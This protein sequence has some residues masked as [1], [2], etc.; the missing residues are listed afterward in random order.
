MTPRSL[1]NIILKVFAL[2]FLRETI[3]AASQLFSAITYF[4]NFDDPIGGILPIVLTVL[5]LA[6]YV[7]L[8]I[9]LLFKTNNFI[10]KL[11]LDR[12]FDEHEFLFD[13]QNKF[14]INISTTL[15]LTIALIVTGGIIL[16]EEI[17]NFC[18]SVYLYLGEDNKIRDNTKSNASYAI[19]SAVKILLG[20]LILGERKR[21]IE[22]IE[23]RQNK[24][25][26]EDQT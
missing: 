14:S 3:N 13:T 11:R 16:T 12:G 9:Q 18:R 21:I 5:V 24:N 22:F 19:V 1:F 8:I 7:F 4:T 10:D 26:D 23:E 25:A 20:L 2:F 15:V 6:F 17:P